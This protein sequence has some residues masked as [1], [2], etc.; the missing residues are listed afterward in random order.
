MSSKKK[1]GTNISPVLRIS[2]SRW[3]DSEV[4]SSEWYGEANPINSDHA[5]EGIWREL[6]FPSGKPYLSTWSIA[7][8]KSLN[9][10]VNAFGKE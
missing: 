4:F 3:S 1:I 5:P 10:Y 2:M 7:K 6:Q 8:E 9:P